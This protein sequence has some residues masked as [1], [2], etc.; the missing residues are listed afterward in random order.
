AAKRRRDS[1]EQFSAGGR[2]YLVDVE[3]RELNLIQKYLPEQ[4]SEDE[5]R[6]KVAETVSALGLKEPSQAGSLMRELMPALKGKADGK[7]INR[8]ARDILAR[9]NSN[10]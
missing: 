10:A 9:E 6:A 3:A 1:I 2:Q 7:L 4:M 5:I 8:I